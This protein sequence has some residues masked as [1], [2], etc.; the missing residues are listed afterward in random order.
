MQYDSPGGGNRLVT[1]LNFYLLFFQLLH[2]IAILDLIN[3]NFSRFE[4]GHVM[5]I[6]YQGG[7][8]RDISGNF[9]LSLL[10]NKAAKTTDVDV[11]TI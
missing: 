1:S 2:L 10:I 4:T 8:A 11:I 9:F 6:Y 3:E 7:V 5:F